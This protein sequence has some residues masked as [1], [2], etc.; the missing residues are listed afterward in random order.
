MF[1]FEDIVPLLR[2][3]TKVTHANKLPQHEGRRETLNFAATSVLFCLNYCFFLFKNYL[4][5]LNWILRK[6]DLIFKQLMPTNWALY[7]IWDIKMIWSNIHFS[8]ANLEALASY[9]CWQDAT[10]KPL[11]NSCDIFVDFIAEAKI[12]FKTTYSQSSLSKLLIDR[13]CTS[14]RKST[15][16]KN[17]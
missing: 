7:I 14:S 16:C 8:H 12:K 9:T 15:F 10:T 3:R 1:K 2:I 4:S 13:L 11:S 5:Y 17:E 6:G